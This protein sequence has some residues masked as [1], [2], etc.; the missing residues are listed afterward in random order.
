[1]IKKHDPAS[2]SYYTIAYSPFVE[3]LLNRGATFI[4]DPIFS[5]DSYYIP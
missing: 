5:F 4:Q 2:D 1:M 3:T